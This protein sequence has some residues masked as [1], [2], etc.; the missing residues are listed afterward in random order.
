[1]CVYRST[2]RADRKK[3]VLITDQYGIYQTVY[4][5]KTV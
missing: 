5:A 3:T 1:M 4:A 2:G